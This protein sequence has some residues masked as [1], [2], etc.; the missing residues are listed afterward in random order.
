MESPCRMHLKAFNTWICTPAISYHSV[1]CQ[2]SVQNQLISSTVWYWLVVYQ[3]IFL[4]MAVYLYCQSCQNI[5]EQHNTV[6]AFITL[7]VSYC[8][9]VLGLCSKK[10]AGKYCFLKLTNQYVKKNVQLGFHTRKS[11]WIET[12]GLKMKLKVRQQL[13]MFFFKFYG[14]SS[15]NSMMHIVRKQQI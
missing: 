2:H 8:Y 12:N 3:I 14:K 5:S 1:H 10:L 7:T 4:S 13:Q 9:L 6:K 15:F 11:I